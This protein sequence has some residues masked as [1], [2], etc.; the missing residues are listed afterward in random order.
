MNY[1]LFQI[2][3]S[4]YDEAGAKIVEKLL[5]KAKARDVKIHLPVDFVTADKFDEN[6]NTNTATVDQGVPDGWMGLDCGPETQKL[7]I[8]P[9]A[10]AKV[11]VWNG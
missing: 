10:R 8:E 6:A 3:D 4:L 5:D 7:F 2:G 11:I 9:V 1:N